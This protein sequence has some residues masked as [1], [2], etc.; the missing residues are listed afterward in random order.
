MLGETMVQALFNRH[1]ELVRNGNWPS[2]KRNSPVYSQPAQLARPLILEHSP[3]SVLGMAVF[4][5]AHV[6]LAMAM[7]EYPSVGVAHAL[8]TLAVG[9]WWTTFR[10]RPE[11]VAYVGAYITGAEVLWRM[12]RAP[13]FWELG[14][15]AVV[16]LFILSIVTRRRVRGPMLTLLYFALLLPSVV[17]TAGSMNFEAAR[18]Q[19]SFN[20]SGPLAI[21]VSAWF[22]SQIELSRKQVLQLFLAL[23][24]P[25][26]GIASL[27]VLSTLKSNQIGFATGANRITSGGFGPN[28]VS[29]VLGL[30]ALM[31]YFYVSDREGNIGL[32]ALT[33]L[34][35]VVFAVQ[36]ALTFSRGGLYIAVGSALAGSLFLIRNNRTR[37]KL[38]LSAAV[39]CGVG[40]YV[41]LPRLDT[42]TQGKLEARFENTKPTGRDRLA[43]AELAAW[44]E[45]PI[46]GLGPGGADSYRRQSLIVSPEDRVASHTEYTRLLA[47]HG[48]LGLIALMSLLMAGITALVRPNTAENKARVATFLVWSL[49]FLAVNG[50]RLVAPSFMFGLAFVTLLGCETEKFNESRRLNYRFMARYLPNRAPRRAQSVT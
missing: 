38:I 3:S 6:P 28:Q 15:Y 44:G 10:N 18:Q 30:G 45:N 5:V 21:L 20:L 23:M 11:R 25:V 1:A 17:L 24:G 2:A 43:G 9:L 47:E 14:K 32:K 50:M 4:L 34:L 31:A 19:V 27:A 36:S 35:M 26:A 37:I 8:A 16:F 48:I 33:L 49:L 12:T 46:L 40:Y 22:F 39:I 29:A 7:R 42:F 13:V 41:V